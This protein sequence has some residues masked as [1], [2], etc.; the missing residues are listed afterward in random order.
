MKYSRKK[1][2]EAKMRQI[3]TNFTT[4]ESIGNWLQQEVDDLLN[5]YVS[6]L[7]MPPC[8]R[9]REEM[10]DICDQRMDDILTGHSATIPHDKVMHRMSEK[11]GLTQPFM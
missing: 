4:T 3:N 8:S 5:D 10:M 9:T 1:I 6:D 2:D 7:S 11:Y